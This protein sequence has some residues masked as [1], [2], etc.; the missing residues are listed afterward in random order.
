M[1]VSHKRHNPGIFTKSNS[2]DKLFWGIPQYLHF[3]KFLKTGAVK[4]LG[5]EHQARP[6]LLLSIDIADEGFH[7]FNL[8]FVC[9]G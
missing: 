2:A 9:G 1:V 3:S 6:I 5:P 7:M 4:V 8:T